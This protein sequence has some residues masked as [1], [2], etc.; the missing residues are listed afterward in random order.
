MAREVMADPETAGAVKPANAKPAT[1]AK[2]AT[3]TVPGRPP[4]AVAETLAAAPTA[5]PAAAP[6]ETPAV[7]PAQAP[8][9]AAPAPTKPTTRRPR[10]LV[11]DDE[12]SI[13]AFLNRALTAVGMECLGYEDGASAWEGIR[14]IGDFDAMLIDHRLVGM[15]G[16]EFF[17]AAVELR[18]E[19][20][21]RA[22]FMSGDVLNPDLHGFATQR[23]IRLLAKPFDV[24][25][26]IATVR[27][28]IVDNSDAE[29]SPDGTGS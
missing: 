9:V 8:A 15:S 10:I 29:S 14:E 13:R 22:I 25:A 21:S 23:G 3:R 17:Q 11:V 5:T 2:A 6:T 19:M 12:P 20:A 26:V 27:K 18:P 7:A 4:E 28:L 1:T 16:T 24:E